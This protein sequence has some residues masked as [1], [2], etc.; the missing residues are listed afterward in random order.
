MLDGGLEV[1]PS[2][3]AGIDQSKIVIELRLVSFLLDNDDDRATLGWSEDIR[4]DESRGTSPLVH[5]GQRSLVQPDS[6]RCHD[7]HSDDRGRGAAYLVAEVDIRGQIPGVDGGTAV[8]HGGGQK[9]N[10]VF[11]WPCCAQS[12]E[13]L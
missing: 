11:S 10:E 9:W 1:T 3:R 2:L 6:Q 7:R 4:L 13:A 5:S 12:R 8:V